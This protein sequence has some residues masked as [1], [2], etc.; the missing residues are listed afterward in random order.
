S[1]RAVGR[2]PRT[3]VNHIPLSQDDADAFFS[4][5]LDL[6]LH[7]ALNT[8][9]EAAPATASHLAE[10]LDDALHRAGRADD[11]LTLFGE[12]LRLAR[13]RGDAEGELRALVDLGATLTL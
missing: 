5:S 1:R 3:E 11:A 13:D 9:D 2:A 4:E 6:L 7:V 10:T 8:S 12:T